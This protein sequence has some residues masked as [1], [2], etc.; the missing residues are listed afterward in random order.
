MNECKDGRNVEYEDKGTQ[1]Y[2]LLSGPAGWLE[3]TP[4]LWHCLVSD[5]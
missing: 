1:P 3:V 2:W 4:T 5:S